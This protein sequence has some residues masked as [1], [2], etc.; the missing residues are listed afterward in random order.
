MLSMTAACDTSKMYQTNVLTGNVTD[1]E[2]ISHYKIYFEKE[3]FSSCVVCT[4]TFNTL[5]N[6]WRKLESSKFKCNWTC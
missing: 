3:M 6:L 5:C 1:T 4:S 2:V